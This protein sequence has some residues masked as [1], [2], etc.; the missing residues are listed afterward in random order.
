MLMKKASLTALAAAM[1]VSG[2]VGAATMDGQLTV[3]ATLTAACELSAPAATM[4]FGSFEALLSAGTQYGTSGVGEIKVAC[5]SGVQPVIYSGDV[6]E[7]SDG[8]NTIVYSL[9][10]DAGRTAALPTDGTGATNLVV[11]TDGQL[12]DVSLY[13]KIDAAAFSGKPAATYSQ[14]VTLNIVYK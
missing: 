13:G 4:S 12:H 9:Y 2:M 7:L 5:S 8:T 10:T 6:L 11:T 3:D 14:V 1:M